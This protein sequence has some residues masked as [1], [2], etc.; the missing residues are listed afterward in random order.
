MASTALTV[1]KGH[2]DIDDVVT[3]VQEP[4]SLRPANLKEAMEFATIIAKSDLVPKDYKGKPEN[5]L[6][7][8]QMGAEIGLPPMQAIQGIAVING[9]PSV[10]GD[11]LRAIILSAPDLQDIVETD[12][13]SKA[14][15]VITRRG[16]SPVTHTFS[17]QDAQAAGLSGGN[18]WKAYPKRMRQNRAFTFAARD[19]Y[20]D[21]LKGL[22]SAEEQQDIETTDVRTVPSEPQRLAAPTPAPAQAPQATSAPS[23]VPATTSPTEDGDLLRGVQFIDSHF[24][25]ASLDGKVKAHYVIET[26]QGEVCTADEQLY[27]EA[28]SCEGPTRFDLHTRLTRRGDGK[29]VRLLLQIHPIADVAPA[30]AADAPAADGGEPPAQQGGL[31]S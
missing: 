18:V 21:R 22:A 6:I 25:A 9:R 15:C 12:D 23:Q 7:A 4:F 13:G 2:E 28:A 29:R 5:C 30:P 26:S 3:L 11:A 19:A 17:M 31:L 1:P 14:T 24:V 8:V 20:A 10:W 16:R 27:K